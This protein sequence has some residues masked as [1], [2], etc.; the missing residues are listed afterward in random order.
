MGLGNL[1][2]T[3]KKKVTIIVYS[4]AIGAKPENEDDIDNDDGKEISL[5]CSVVQWSLRLHFVGRPPHYYRVAR[6]TAT[7]A[8]PNVDRNLYISRQ[9]SE[10]VRDVDDLCSTVN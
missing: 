7:T 6:H 5:L 3:G 10:F 2:R 1:R 4:L 8:I 9:K